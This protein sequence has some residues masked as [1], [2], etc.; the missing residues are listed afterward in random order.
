MGKEEERSQMSQM[1]REES[2]RD[3]EAGEAHERLLDY[4]LVNAFSSASSRARSLA[5]GIR[6]TA[7]Y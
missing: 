7:Q 3:R 4:S 2:W 6:Y 5:H 1:G